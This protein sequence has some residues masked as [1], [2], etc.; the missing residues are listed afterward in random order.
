[1]NEESNKKIIELSK[2]FLNYIEEDDESY[3]DDEI[4]S[5]AK[6]EISGKI[7][8][9]TC[10]ISPFN[11]KLKVH[12]AIDNKD[13][14][15]IPEHILQSIKNNNYKTIQNTLFST[16]K[17][18][19]LLFLK[20]II[21]KNMRVNDEG[22]FS[23]DMRQYIPLIMWVADQNLNIIEEESSKC[24]TS[25]LYRDIKNFE[26]KQKQ[27]EEKKQ[28]SIKFE[29]SFDIN[30]EDDKR[31]QQGLPPLYPESA[32]YKA[33]YNSKMENIY[34]QP[35]KKYPS[36]EESNCKYYGMTSY[37]EMC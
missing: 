15:Y 16:D 20:N 5:L 34:K 8:N 36:R 7:I 10:D 26:N 23:S 25:R 27:T 19:N 2:S 24:I 21:T 4:I 13:L 11:S 6:E 37:G 1:M 17:L 12:E 33:F 35:E 9:A 28:N 14:S 30:F 29:R 32:Y 3:T 18:N 31:M 22:Y